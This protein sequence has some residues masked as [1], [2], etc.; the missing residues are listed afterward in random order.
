MTDYRSVK[1]PNE[2]VKEIEKLI[3]DHPELGYRTH[4]EFVIEATRNHLLKIK[5]ATELL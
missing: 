1:V 5:K 3:L 4:S 2:L